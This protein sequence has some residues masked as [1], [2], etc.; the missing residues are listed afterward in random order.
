MPHQQI[1]LLTYPA[2]QS[3]SGRITIATAA[4]Y[5]EEVPGT[6]WEQA[7]VIRHDHHFFKLLKYARLTWGTVLT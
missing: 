7:A 4:K 5:V 2:C 3:L 1:N 6:I